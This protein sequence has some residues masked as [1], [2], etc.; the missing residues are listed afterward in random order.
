MSQHLQLGLEHPDADLLSAFAENAL[1]AHEREPL[2][3]HLATCADCRQIVALSLPPQETPELTPAIVP[4]PRKSSLLQ[5]LSGWNLALAGGLAFAAIALVAVFHHRA[6]MTNAPAQSA[7]NEPAPEVPAPASPTAKEPPP[8]PSRAVQMPAAPPRFSPLVKG[9]ESEPY[10][11]APAA[12]AIT[13]DGIDT[14]SVA[15]LPLNGRNYQAIPSAKPAPA[16]GS[17]MGGMSAGA[18]S[19]PLTPAKTPAPVNNYL[20]PTPPLAQAQ[21]SVNVSAIAPQIVTNDATVNGA[22]IELLPAATPL[23]SHLTVASILTRDHQTLALDTA[24]ALFT[25]ADAGQHWKPVHTP[26]GSRAVCLRPV[27]ALENEIPCGPAALNTRLRGNETLSA[28]IIG[29]ITDPS[30]ATIPGATITVLGPSDSSARTDGSGRYAIT[31]LSSGNYRLRTSAPGFSSVDM[32][33]DVTGARP[34]TANISLPLGSV[35]ETVEV[36]SSAAAV[37]TESAAPVAKKAKKEEPVFTIETANGEHWLS[38]DGSHWHK[39]SKPK[40]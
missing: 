32:S 36:T 11:K 19:A 37:Q 16:R 22:G 17:V 9:S 2:L 38:S 12:P 33:L 7:H 28:S 29:V 23:P 30:G 40:Q 13:M 34:V 10:E 35:S 3:L 4:E 31:N 8:P 6:S 14:R 18:A 20:A 24:G 5:W 21:D 1:P 27:S 15:N 25:S 26:W 39:E